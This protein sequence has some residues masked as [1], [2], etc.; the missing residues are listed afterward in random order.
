MKT[1]TSQ[2]VKT[3]RELYSPLSVSTTQLYQ[4][5]TRKTLWMGKVFVSLNDQLTKFNRPRVKE[6]HWKYI[7]YDYIMSITNS[8]QDIDRI[9]IGMIEITSRK[10]G[11]AIPVISSIFLK[12]SFEIGAIAKS[13]LTVESK[14]EGSKVI[15]KIGEIV[16]KIPATT[17]NMFSQQ[18]ETFKRLILRYSM[19]GVD[20]GLF[21]SMP[22]EVIKYFD[23]GL[24]PTLECFASPFN[25][26]ARNF[27]SAFEEDKKLIYP[28]GYTCHGD[29]KAMMNGLSL[30]MKVRFLFNP[31]YIKK[32]ISESLALI[33]RFLESSPSSEI[34]AML[35]NRQYEAVSG[36]INSPGT[37]Y[38]I[39][40]SN[41]YKIY[42]HSQQISFSP[43]GLELLL[44]V[45][46]G[47]DTAYSKR[48]LNLIVENFFA[49]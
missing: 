40:K 42:S 32:I 35:P 14:N 8:P 18:D 39:L 45:R 49:S 31:P 34:I 9:Y 22:P 21:W 2:P 23:D 24:Q 38:T 47:D 5:A 3:I 7:V 37:A 30:G 13:P 1:V 27:C 15:V 28:D 4:E 10:T 25:F 48:V 20:T 6:E 43:H 26:T 11:L 17:Y 33:M 29:F 12:A 41:D 36:L 16:E 46:F 44:I 19:F